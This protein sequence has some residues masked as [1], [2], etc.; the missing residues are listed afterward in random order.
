MMRSIFYIFPD[1]VVSVSGHE[2]AKMLSVAEAGC[3]S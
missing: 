1:G 3:D 2:I